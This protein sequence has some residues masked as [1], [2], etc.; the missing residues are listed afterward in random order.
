[1]TLPLQI[2]FHIDA[3]SLRSGRYRETVQHYHSALRLTDAVA[4]EQMPRP[5]AFI[6]L[7]DAEKPLLSDAIDALYD[8]DVQPIAQ[9]GTQ[10]RERG[11]TDLRY[12]LE[13][14]AIHRVPYLLHL[15]SDHRI[16]P[17]AGQNLR[18]ILAAACNTL[19]ANKDVV[20]V[21]FPGALN[22][23]PG[24]QVSQMFSVA[25]ILRWPAVVR[26]RDLYLAA[27]LAQSSSA[28]SDQLLSA[29]SQSQVRHLAFQQSIATVQ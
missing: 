6:R 2:L 1:M 11:W 8:W 5:I 10:V 3:D 22:L 16:T 7:T 23:F 24:Q 27:V 15:A 18:D 25:Q 21:G 12:I 28:T 13:T 4:Y 14:P 20:T 26:T 19:A 9:D 17:A 29:F